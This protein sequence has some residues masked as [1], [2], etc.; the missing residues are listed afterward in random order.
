MMLYR[1]M[2]DAAMEF[3]YEGAKEMIL[4]PQKG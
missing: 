2:S 3:P 1:R 4:V